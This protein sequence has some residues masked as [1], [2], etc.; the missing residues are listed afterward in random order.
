MRFI[1]IL[2]IFHIS[3]SQEKASFID[4]LQSKVQQKEINEKEALIESLKYMF[5]PYDRQFQAIKNGTQLINAYKSLKSEFSL[6]EQSEIDRLLSRKKMRKK[7]ESYI[8]PSGLFQLTYE[9]TGTD[10]VITESLD[11]DAIPDYVQNAALYLDHSHDFLVN[12]KSYKNPQIQNRKYL[13]YFENMSAYGYNYESNDGL[14]T[15]IVLNSTF[16][17]FAS[18]T[19]PEG[20]VKGSL[21]VTAAH[22][23]KHAIQFK[24]D[25]QLYSDFSDYWVELDATWTE[26]FVYPEVNDYYNYLTNSS[27]QIAYPYISMNNHN[28][29]GSYFDV[30]WQLYL[31]QRFGENFMNDLWKRRETNFNEPF[32]TTY[33]KIIENNSETMTNVIREYSAWNYLVA[34]RYKG[35]IGYSDASHFP[36]SVIEDIFDYSAIYTN[37][38]SHFASRQILFTGSENQFLNIEITAE[39]DL[40]FAIVYTNSLDQSVLEK[41]NFN[42]NTF[43]YHFQDKMINIS[44]VALIAVNTKTSSGIREFSVQSSWSSTAGQNEQI[45]DISLVANP[46]QNQQLII[47]HPNEN[48][49]HDNSVKIYNLLGKKISNYKLNNLSTQTVISLPNSLASGIYYAHVIFGNHSQSIKFIFVK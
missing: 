49:Q 19:D 13:V 6:N 37:T 4:H 14:T 43:T 39:E 46:I 38:I 42:T 28:N 10:S 18:N 32:L 16:K 3:F 20:N 40:S 25:K 41:L 12:Q 7:S 29:T 48:N 35:S 24:I 45:A 8:S 31:S 2:F 47:S 44:D 30:A 23:Y 26:E 21:K 15:E 17:G 34:N 9:L 33:Q 11:G 22:E 36:K 1:L 27:S 5:K